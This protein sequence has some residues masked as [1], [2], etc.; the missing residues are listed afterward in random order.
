MQICDIYKIN[1]HIQLFETLASLNVLNFA[2]IIQGQIEIFEFFEFI[3]IFHLLN[4]IIL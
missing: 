4:D 2:D 3:Q 1:S